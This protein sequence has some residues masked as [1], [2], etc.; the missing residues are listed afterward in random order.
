MLKNK[1]N[2]NQFLFEIDLIR[3]N[4]DPIKRLII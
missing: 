3:N 1:E 2:Q 4:R